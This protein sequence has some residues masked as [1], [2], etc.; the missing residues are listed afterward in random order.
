[1]ANTEVIEKTVEAAGAVANVG[2]NEVK[3]FL[4]GLLLGAVITAGVGYSVKTVVAVRKA[5]KSKKPIVVTAD[6]V[7]EVED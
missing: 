6:E 5:T 4:S 1:M 2:N 3:Y 7:V